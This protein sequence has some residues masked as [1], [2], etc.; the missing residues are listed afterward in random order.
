MRTELSRCWRILA[1]ALCFAVFGLGGLLLNTLGF[2]LLKLW[3]P[4]PEQ[5]SQYARLWLHHLFRFFVRLMCGLGILRVQVQGLEKLQR[6]G[7]LIVANHP[8]L[9]DVVFL[10]SFLRRANCVVKADLWRNL[11]TRGTMHTADFLCANSGAELI[12]LAKYSLQRGDHLIIFPQGT[13]THTQNKPL[14]RGAAQVAV[15]THTNITPVRIYCTPP[16]LTKTRPWYKVPTV[17]SLF[18]IEV[19]Q[20]IEVHPFCERSRSPAI[21]ARHLTNHL[22]DYFYLEARR[23]PA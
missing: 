1:S 3:T 15:R 19:G 7:L 16:M 5:R 6:P 22:A 4:S 10:I 20:D 8:T 17:P 2:K 11:F 13:R 18:V 23:E 21:A 12:E 14:H 9:I